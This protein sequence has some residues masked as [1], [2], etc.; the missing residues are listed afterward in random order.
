VVWHLMM[1]QIDSRHW[2]I[3]TSRHFQNDR[4][5]IAQIQHCPISKNIFSLKRRYDY[6]LTI[7]KW[8]LPNQIMCFLL[9]LDSKPTADKMSI[10]KSKATFEIEQCWIVAVLWRPFWKWR[11]DRAI[12]RVGVFRNMA[13][14]CKILNMP[15]YFD[16][17]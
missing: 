12:F 7:M 13:F 14:H 1:S 3:S 16:R 11:P 2:K 17:T 9:P 4:H 10:N 8:S 5:N 15:W 6:N